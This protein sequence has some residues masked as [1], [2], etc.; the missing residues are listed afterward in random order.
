MKA[1]LHIGTEKTGSTSIQNFIKENKKEL[2]KHICIPNSLGFNH[3]PLAV[4]AYQENKIDSFRI[5]NNILKKEDFDNYKNNLFNELKQEL[6]GKTKILFTSELIHSRLTTKEE[7]I[8]LKEILHKLGIND[9]K[10][11]IYLREQGELINSLYSEAIKW[12]EIDEKFDFELKDSFDLEF[13]DGF[14][15]NISHFQFICDHKNTLKIWQEV[16][17]LDN[18]IPTIFDKKYFKNQD[19]ISDFLDKI[20]ID[21][22]DSFNKIDNSNEALDT[23]GVDLLLYL[24][25]ELPMFINNKSNPLRGD[26]VRY[27]NKYFTD[28]KHNYKLNNGIIENIRKFYKQDNDYIISTYFNH[29]QYFTYKNFNDHN[30]N[31]LSFN[32]KAF[33]VDFVKEKNQAITQLKQ[34][35][36]FLKNNNVLTQD[37][38]DI[39]LS[40]T[41]AYKLGNYINNFTK[42]KFNI[43]Y[44]FKYIA[45]LLFCYDNK[46]TKM[47]LKKINK[48]S[49]KNTK[50]YRNYIIG[51]KLLKDKN[52]Y[53]KFK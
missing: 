37:E 21:N 35:I 27:I 11:I 29:K 10:I 14:R 52:N 46:I 1:F 15:K 30:N 28:K 33:I 39:L 50:S 22:I 40:N 6:K 20:E 9:I 51:L 23:Y 8:Q 26:I 36:D 5:T 18:I 34:S 24:N 32:T 7:L 48:E 47:L 13:K 17:G 2:Q 41:K 19:L 42:N 43:L 16:F 44:L 25:K 45:T 12:S 49:I 3:W 31:I 53:D 4:L 38:I